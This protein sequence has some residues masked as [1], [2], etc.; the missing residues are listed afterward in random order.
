MYKKYR[1][2]K[3]SL[4]HS[5]KNKNFI[6]II[7]ILLFLLLCVSFI[8]QYFNNKVNNFI[9]NDSNKE[10]FVFTKVDINFDYKSIEYNF[11]IEKNF[12]NRTFY[13]VSSTFDETNR[14][15][16]IS[17]KTKLD[18]FRNYK[19]NLSEFDV[20]YDN[21]LDENFILINQRFSEFMFSKLHAGEKIEYTIFIKDYKDIDK[22][23]NYL[24][25]NNIDFNFNMDMSKYNTYLNLLL[26]LKY[27]YAFTKLLFT[28]IIIILV[29]SFINEQKKNIR[30]FKILG[31][32][33]V[34]VVTMI[35][36]N[37]LYLIFMLLIALLLFFSIGIYLLNISLYDYIIS[38]TYFMVILILVIFIEIYFLLNYKYY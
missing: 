4:K 21:S 2:F 29:Y 13:I 33:K 19:I 5:N 25:K 11:N 12:D 22:I 1:I 28:T 27:S 17:E 30:I 37:I 23:S 38:M 31:Y 36:F 35:F 16:K 10:L 26:I 7:S 20:I 3:K 8:L 14:T 15:V 9:N 6:L 24:N 34:S 32:K 18:I